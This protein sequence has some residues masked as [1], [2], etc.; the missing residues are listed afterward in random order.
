MQTMFLRFPG[1]KAKALTFSY[2]DNVEQDVQLID[3]FRKHG[4]RATFNL[5][6]GRF[7]PEGTVHPEGQIHRRMTPS[8]VKATYADDVC[9][10]A[11]HS[12]THPWLTACSSAVV[13]HQVIEDR[14]ALESMFKT[15]VPGMAYPYGPTNDTVVDALRACGIYY[16]R[17]T[18]ST[19]KFDMPT[20]WL[21]L[22]ATCHHNEPKLMELADRFLSLT[23]SRFP[24]LFY[25]WGHSYEFERD[26]NW[27]VIEDF[28][29]KMADKEDIWYATNIEI[30]TAWADYMR[31]ETSADG[32]MIFN[33]NC[34]SVWI[35]DN[36]NQVYEIKPGETLYT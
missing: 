16:A 35:A 22:P 31:L 21:R 13:C 28:C 4:M 32:S 10:V 7:D 3:I 14:K 15:R 24:Q 33:P 29:D 25:V 18:V 36:S 19:L 9:E 17:T 23:P 30:Y 8:Q 1:G 2:D 11:C 26:N 12:Y 27:H 34:R 5:N 20:D 6:G